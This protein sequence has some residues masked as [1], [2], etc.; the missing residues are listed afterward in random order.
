ME[1]EWPCKTFDCGDTSNEPRSGAGIL[2]RVLTP[3]NEIEFVPALQ[4]AEEYA[5]PSPLAGLHFVCIDFPGLKPRA[6]IP[7]PLRGS[8]H[9]LSSLRGSLDDLSS[10]RGSLDDLSSL[11]GS[12]DDLSS[13]RGSL[14]DLSSLRGSLDDLSPLRGS[15]DDLSPL[16]FCRKLV[17]RNEPGNYPDQ[18]ELLQ[19]GK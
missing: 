9:D 15:L 2:A 6:K 17:A 18:R 3:G 11:R 4:G 10:L 1:V 13:L 19:K 7:A 12:L 5:F 16:C 14:D 8:L